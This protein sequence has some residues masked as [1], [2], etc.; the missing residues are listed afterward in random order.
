MRSGKFHS[1]SGKNVQKFFYYGIITNEVGILISKISIKISG[2]CERI[3]F[4]SE[5]ERVITQYGTE[6]FLDGFIKVLC[7]IIV[8]CLL[9]KTESFFIFIIVFCSLRCFAGGFH[10]KTSIGCFS[11]MLIFCLISVY[12]AKFCERIPFKLISI[13]GIL[14][15]SIV[16]LGAPGQTLRNPINDVNIM[17]SKQNLSLLWLTLEYIFALCIRD[18]NLRWVIIISAFLEVCSLIPCMRIHIK[19]R[20]RKL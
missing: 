4:L 18:I 8:G 14:C 12:G 2:W 20:R 17:K 11:V 6:V 7:L 16:Y 19:Q 9:G 3:L 5:K 15:Y 1:R 10:C 13:I